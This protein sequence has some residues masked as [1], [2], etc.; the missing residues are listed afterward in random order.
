M[1]AHL[2]K[3][4]RSSAHPQV[5]GVRSFRLQQRGTMAAGAI[6][7]FPLK[8]HFTVPRFLPF[9]RMNL[10]FCSR[11]AFSIFENI[12][13]SLRYIT[14]RLIHM[15]MRCITF[16]CDSIERSRRRIKQPNTDDI[17]K[18][19]CI[20]AESGVLAGRPGKY[21]VTDGN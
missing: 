8:R 19:T 13:L 18:L 1:C 4:S 14:S 21:I 11:F 9:C 12:R 15:L 16:P 2:A 20:L 10:F 17:A 3:P 5:L 6:S 7:S